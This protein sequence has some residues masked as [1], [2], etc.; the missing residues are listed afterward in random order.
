[1]EPQWYRNGT[2]PETWWEDWLPFLAHHRI[3][4]S[5]L[6]GPSPIKEYQIL[7]DSGAKWMGLAGA[8]GPPAQPVPSSQPHHYDEFVKQLIQ[9]LTPTM[10]SMESMGMLGTID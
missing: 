3:P 5:S 2:Q 4:G 9:T 10:N 8:G 7:A 6:G 1:M